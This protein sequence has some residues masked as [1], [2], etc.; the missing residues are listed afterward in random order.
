MKVV[1]LRRLLKEELKVARNF[2]EKL[3]FYNL[4]LKKIILLFW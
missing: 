3:N 1:K 2:L 4:A